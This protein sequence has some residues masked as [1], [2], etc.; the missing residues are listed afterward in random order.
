MKRNL[1][2]KKI[3]FAIS[4][5]ALFSIA[6]NKARKTIDENDNSI[7]QTENNNLNRITTNS[8]EVFVTNGILN[9]S[10]LEVYET[11]LQNFE[12]KSLQD[13]NEWISNFNF[14]SIHSIGIP[15][16]T[17]IL[18]GIEGSPI[19]YILNSNYLVKIGTR[20]CLLDFS[21]SEVYVTE[22][23]DEN[24]IA[25]LINKQIN[26]TNIFKFPFEADV[27][28]IE[29]LANPEELQTENGGQNK[30]CKEKG[31]PWKNKENCSDADGCTYGGPEV[32]WK[33]KA[34]V[35]YQAFGI[36]FRIHSKLKHRKQGGGINSG[37]TTLLIQSSQYPQIGNH[38][39]KPKCKSIISSVWSTQQNQNCSVLD[40]NSYS[41]GKALNTYNI[42]VDFFWVHPFTLNSTTLP[43]HLEHL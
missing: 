13:K 42:Y 32:Y 19:E 27:L 8:Q 9:F 43:L 37:P 10:S 39:I 16:E 14:S 40:Y 26:T 34:K 6:C 38:L 17:E 21:T 29:D 3:I 33:V 11:F 24:I 7:T 1:Y 15:P 18:F 5:I 12:N 41:A 20:T 30:K 4:A 35:V 25:Q 22:S 23:D 31:A 2:M 36:N 28:Y